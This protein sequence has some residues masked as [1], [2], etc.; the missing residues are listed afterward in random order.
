MWL[1]DEIKV[2]TDKPALGRRGLLRQFVEWLEARDRTP[3]ELLNLCLERITSRDEQVRA[4]V[5]V[6]P[7]EALAKGPLSGIPFGAKDIYETRNLA[8]EYGS[9]VYAGR[10][11]TA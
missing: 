3:D 9:Q 2:H 6:E 5:Q 11:G 10:K 4:W 7:Q 8:T 1:A